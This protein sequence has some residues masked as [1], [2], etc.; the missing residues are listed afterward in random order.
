MKTILLSWGLLV[1]ACAM[2]ASVVGSK[3]DLSVAGGGSVKAAAE[4]D[5]CIFCHTPHNG[6][7]DAP[8]WNRYSSGVFYTPYNST[9]MKASVGQPTGAS[10]L[11]LSCH[12]GTVAL[13]M[14]RSR[15]RPIPMA[16]GAEKMPKGRTN[17][18]T[19]LSDDH[20]VSFSYDAALFGKNK[21][22]RNPASLKGTVRPDKSGQLQC[23]SCHDA[24]NNQF[25][26]FLVMNNE[27]SALCVTCHDKGYW[28]DSDHRTSTRTWNGQGQD[29][30]PH[31][32]ATTV[33]ANGCENC[34]SPHVAGTP[35][36]LM[37][38]A[39]EEQNCYPCH[40]GNVASKNIQAEFAKYSRH[41][42]SATTG[43]HD[44]TEDIASSPRHVECAD[45][46]N[47]H[48][49]RVGSVGGMAGGLVGVAG[50]SASGSAVET[51]S[52]EYEI[53]FRCHE[54]RAA[55]DAETITRQ[56]NESN[57]RLQFAPGNAS[58]HPVVA[59]GKNP[60]VP[61]LVSSYTPS[62]L[63]A[64]TDCHNNDQG[65]VSGGKGPNGPHG[66]SY[67]PLLA[68]KLVMKDYGAESQASYALCY[69]CHSRKSILANESFP[70][71]SL[72]V[73]DQKTA[74]TTCHDSHGVSSA[75]HLINFNSSY[76]SATSSGPVSYQSTGR[77]Q[78]SCTLTCHG[79]VHESKTYGTPGST[80]GTS[81]SA[82]SSKR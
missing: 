42:V 46:H 3:H 68:Q 27:Q 15:T 55:G 58:Y 20:P 80:T 5:V 32:A 11:C 1:P 14:V 53:C 78:G 74:C 34:H 24:H 18:G 56:M 16:G 36:R 66:S 47:P 51:A 44:P 23:T 38:F 40:N 77:D 57:L 69:R 6:S 48:A 19:D 12:D 30:W 22:L 76:V 39:S 62:S 25:G 9:T 21:E 8:L 54:N 45:C 17:L 26:R 79:T 35:A 81:S 50:V 43:V 65:P 71:H 70:A 64:C 82:S 10:K 59:A 61:S 28:V 13:G 49:A 72:H 29:P 2:A 7:A 41:D 31:T 73:V 4:T 33:A 37:N 75:A 67:S 60:N 63:I 52:H